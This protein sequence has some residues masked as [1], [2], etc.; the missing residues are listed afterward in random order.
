[1]RCFEIR[2]FDRFGKYLNSLP[3]QV[4]TRGQAYRAARLMLGGVAVRFEIEEI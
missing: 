1:M 3:A 2:L 4:T